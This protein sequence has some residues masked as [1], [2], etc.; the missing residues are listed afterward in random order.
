[1]LDVRGECPV[2][3][4]VCLCVTAR[5]HVEVLSYTSYGKGCHGSYVKLNGTA[6]WYSKSHRPNCTGVDTPGSFRGTNIHLINP[7]T[8]SRIEFKVFDT[9]ELGDDESNKLHAYLD[10]VDDFAVITGH[11]F[12]EALRN[13]KSNAHAAL[14]R[15]GVDVSD[16]QQGGS[17]AFVTQKSTNKTV[18]SKVLTM[19]ES[20]KNPGTVS[21]M[22][23][24]T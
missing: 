16:I 10:K 15:V 22:I 20:K 2:S 23:T 13:L 14:L 17:F 19:T 3:V 7:F 1:M 21:V 12:D 6:I 5:C 8:C 9:W 4:C 24:G 18:L 11:S